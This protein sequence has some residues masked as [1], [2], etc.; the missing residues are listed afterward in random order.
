MGQTTILKK[1]CNINQDQ[2]SMFFM[3]T[4]HYGFWVCHCPSSN[5]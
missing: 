1:H 5:Q 2:I 4:S 3:V